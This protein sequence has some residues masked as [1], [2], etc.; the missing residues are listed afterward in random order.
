MEESAGRDGTGRGGA[1]RGG[2][3]MSTGWR[4]LLSGRLGCGGGGL[5]R[6]CGL[7]GG[8]RLLGR[9]RRRFGRLLLFLLALGYQVQVL[10]QVAVREFGSVFGGAGR[11][12]KAA[13]TLSSSHRLLGRTRCRR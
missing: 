13:G 5:G 6:L 11:S 4:L 10:V 7:R 9:R 1:G 8:R 12:G 3:S 2:A